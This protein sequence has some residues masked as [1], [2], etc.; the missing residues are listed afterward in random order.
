MTVAEA[1]RY[2]FVSRTHVLKLLAAGKLSEVLP[3]EPDGE[4]NID[5]FSVEAY[6]N[7]T[8]YAQRAYLDSQSEDD[9]PPGL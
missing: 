7:T 2:L 8:E 4:L 9:N 6:R 3:G 5:F 1:A